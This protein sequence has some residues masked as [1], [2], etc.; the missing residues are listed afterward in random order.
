MLKNSEFNDYNISRL[1]L[2]DIKRDLC[3]RIIRYIKINIKDLYFFNFN[4]FLNVAKQIAKISNFNYFLKTSNRARSNINKFIKKIRVPATQRV[5][6]SQTVNPIV[7]LIIYAT[8]LAASDPRL[9]QII[10]GIE[11]LSV[12]ID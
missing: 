2:I 11:K 9:N 5:P 12:Y 8:A 1:F 4:Y 10:Q 7:F 6:L 3:H